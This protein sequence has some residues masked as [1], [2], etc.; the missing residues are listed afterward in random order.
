MLSVCYETE[1]FCLALCFAVFVVCRSNQ[2]CA[3]GQNMTTLCCCH[4]RFTIFAMSQ[5]PQKLFPDPVSSVHSDIIELQPQRHLC[6]YIISRKEKQLDSVP[7]SHYHGAND[8]VSG[9]TVF[10]IHGVAGSVEVWRSQFDSL[11]AEHTVKRIVAIDLIGHGRSSAPRHQEAYQFEAIALDIKTLFIQFRSNNNIII[12]HSYGYKVFFLVL[13]L[14]LLVLVVDGLVSCS[15]YAPKS[16]Q[17]LSTL[18]FFY[19]SVS[20]IIGLYESHAV[21]MLLF[22]NLMD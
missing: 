3:V 14:L 19:Y 18:L 7:V 5:Q 6:I 16:V 17:H 13:A 11:L 15:Y 9:V 1:S 22:I 12:G 2:V 10:L 4:K 21:G 8:I 20:M